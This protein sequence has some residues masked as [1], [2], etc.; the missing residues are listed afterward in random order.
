MCAGKRQT[1]G[2]QLKKAGEEVIEIVKQIFIATAQRLRREY[3]NIIKINCYRRTRFYG[4][5]HLTIISREAISQQTTKSKNSGGIYIEPPLM[6]K[7][8]G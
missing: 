6:T 8:C 1:T 5:A 3:S 2:E 7:P 4:M